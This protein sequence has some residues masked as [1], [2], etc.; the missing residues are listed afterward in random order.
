MKTKSLFTAALCSILVCTLAFGQRMQ[1]PNAWKPNGTMLEQLNLSD[2]QKKDFDNINTDFAKQRIEQ[3]AKIKLAALDL[4]ALLKADSPDRSAIEKKVD[5]VSNLQAQ[6]RML[7]FDHWFAINKILN[8]DQ[9]KTWKSLLDRPFGDRFATRSGRM[10][11][12]MMMQSP[13]RQMS[14]QRPGQ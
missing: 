11:G 1:R 2:S 4:R 12:G 10:R 8:P 14:P 13:R 6:N 3:Q 7:R 9:Q 5:E